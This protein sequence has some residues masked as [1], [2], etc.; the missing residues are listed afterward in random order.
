MKFTSQLLQKAERHV[1]RLQRSGF[2]ALR[3]GN[4]RKWLKVQK[5]LLKSYYARVLA[6]YRV[7]KVNKGRKTKGI[8]G[9]RINPKSTRQMR[10][11]LKK[12][13]KIVTGTEKWVHKPVKRV[14]IPKPDGRKRPLGIPTQ[15]DRVMQAIVN[16][17]LFVMQEYQIASNGLK[18]F[19]FRK[20]FKTA[21]A[22]KTLAPYAWLGTK[23]KVIE[24]DI[25]KCFDRIDHKAI[26]NILNSYECNQDVAEMVKG[27]LQAQILFGDV[28]IES[29]QG[30]P[31]GGIL[32]PTIANIALRET[33]DKKFPEAIRKIKAKNGCQL[34]TYADDLIIIQNGEGNPKKLP[35]ILKIVENLI[36][37]IGLN[38]KQEKTRIIDGEPFEFLGYEI[39]RGKGIRLKP[40]IIKR[41]RQKLK[42]SLEYGRKRDRVLKEINPIL[43]GVYNYAGY[44][45]SKKMWKQTSQ[46][47]FDVGKRFH[48]LY[49]EYGYN[50]IVQFTDVNKTINYI[51]P[52]RPTTL[53]DIDYWNARN[54]KGFPDRKRTLWRKQKGIC[55]ICNRKLGYEPSMLQ[56]H[57]L[58]PKSKGGKDKNS[59]VVLI[60][61]ECHEALHNL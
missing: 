27:C 18:S 16:N 35:Q 3:N 25:E 54:L 8:D 32:S 48:K 39:Q 53:Q 24:A 26:L 4:S 7:T 40:D 20:G 17:I 2:E 31:Q 42:Q 22:V 45:S 55:P 47:G 23:A 41:T 38:L 1:N 34:I 36:Q 60:H 29:R 56:T 49:G 11:I 9:I 37:E 12:I 46:L 61:K 52:Q 14:E 33:L 30:T 19:G 43:R 13:K 6:L 21:D 51:P 57:H 28:F 59:N 50:K 58:T 44:F 15:F 10:F 5:L